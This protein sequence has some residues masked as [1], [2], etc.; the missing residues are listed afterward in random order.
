MKTRNVF[1][2][3]I[4]TAVV[5][6]ALAGCEKTKRSP[7]D[8]YEEV[9]VQPWA[10]DSCSFSWTD[11]NSTMQVLNYFSGHDYTILSHDGDTLML[12]GWIYFHGPGEPIL[13]P[14]VYDSIEGSQEA[15]SPEALFINMVPN[16]NHHGWSQSVRIDWDRPFIQSHPDFREN[17]DD[18]LQKKWF[19]KVR[20]QA[21]QNIIASP[22]LSYGFSLHLVDI[23]SIQTI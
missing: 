16:E 8:C 5:A 7:Y 4:A 21:E 6:M 22:C 10:P 13:D 20:L 23:D 12:W 3:F 2:L 15:W 17:F 11:Y 14:F 1:Y 9:D 19:I 18:Y